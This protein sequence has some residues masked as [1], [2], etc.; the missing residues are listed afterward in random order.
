MPQCNA[1]DPGKK[2]LRSS[3]VLPL[4]RSLHLLLR[5][6]QRIPQPLPQVRRQAQ[7]AVRRPHA[8]R[9]ALFIAARAV[10]EGA[11][12]VHLEA[13]E[14]VLR[15]RDAAVGRRGARVGDVHV[16]RGA[17]A[18]HAALV[19]GAA[20]PAAAAAHAQHA[21]AGRGEGGGLGRDGGVAV[22]VRAERGVQEGAEGGVLGEGRGV[23]GGGGAMAESEARGDGRESGQKGE[24][25]AVWEGGEGDAKL[26]IVSMAGSMEEREAH[27][28]VAAREGR[29]GPPERKGSGGPPARGYPGCA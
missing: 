25:D 7:A 20:R 16:A 8:V 27:N 3:K 28:V 24:I 5:P 12:P 18:A 2:L 17:A 6:V 1:I 11:A 21:P 23:E 9:A 26:G 10:D 22:R 19:A 13:A 29:E 15:V 14:D 4:R